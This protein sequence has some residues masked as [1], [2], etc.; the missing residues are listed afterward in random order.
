MD[1][2][3]INKNWGVFC[4]WL[5]GAIV[6]W[7][8][9]KDPWKICSSNPEW[10]HNHQYR[11]K[12]EVE[13][14][15]KYPGLRQAVINRKE[16][17]IKVT[18]EQ[19]KEIENILIEL[20]VPNAKNDEFY[21]EIILFNKHYY[22]HVTKDYGIGNIPEFYLS[23]DSFNAPLPEW[24][25]EGKKCILERDGES[26]LVEIVR[27]STNNRVCVIEKDGNKIFA[28][29]EELSPAVL[30]PPTYESLLPFAPLALCVKSEKIAKTVLRMDDKAVYFSCGTHCNL[31][32]L[33][34]KYTFTDGSEIGEWVKGDK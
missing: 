5:N 19:S 31:E 12:P 29:I 18:P 34:E 9:G 7:T 22:F 1:R 14:P 17:F 13:Q 24:I 2:E 23:T 11:I 33:H 15:C 25:V 3:C 32:D 4:A 26:L 21:S 6:E 27:E 30:R 8:D 20:K 28:D 10:K 16:F